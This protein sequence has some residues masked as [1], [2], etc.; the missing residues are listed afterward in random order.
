MPGRLFER[1]VCR[2]GGL[3]ASA[4]DGLRAPRSAALL[5]R[6]AALDDQQGA[7][8]E[9]LSAQ[10]FAAVGG[11]GDPAERRRLLALRRQLHNGRPPD[12]AMVGALPGALAAALEPWTEIASESAA[13]EESLPAIFAGEQAAA[14][15]AFRRQLADRD[16]QHGLLISSRG[17]FAGLPRYLAAGELSAKDRQIERGLL[18]YFTR[19]ALKAT[20]FST[21]CAILPGRIET[22]PAAAGEKLVRLRGEASGKKSHIR[23][24]KG[25]LTVFDELFRRDRLLR[26]LFEVELNPTLET[27]KPGQ[28]RFLAVAGRREIFQRLPDHPVLGLIGALLPTLEPRPTLGRLVAALAAHPELEAD[29]ATI[30]PYLDRLLEIGLL[31]LTFGIPAQDLDWDLEFRR[32]MAGVPAAAA[33]CRFLEKARSLADTYAAA[34]A[35][36]RAAILDRLEELFAPWRTGEWMSHSLRALIYE[37]AGAEAEA[38]VAA[39]DVEEIGRDLAEYVQRTAGL[40]ASR[41]DLATMRYF[42]DRFYAGE[43]EVPLLR[44]YEDFY[45]EVFKRYIEQEQRS[46]RGEPVDEGYDLR[47]PLGLEALERRSA[48][49]T[50]LAELVGER[51]AAASLG[52]ELHL[53]TADLD[54][55]L[56]ETGIS[57]PRG[58][59]G[60]VSMYLDLFRGEAGEPSAVLRGG[61]YF[62]GYGKFFSRFLYL[63]PADFE[64][65][66]LR[67]NRQLC[68][69]DALAEINDDAN[70]NPNLHPP[71][72]EEEIRYP[73]ADPRSAG[74]GLLPSDLVLRRD[75]SADRLMLF[76]PPSGRRILPVDT[77]FLNSDARPPLYR[78]LGAFTPAPSFT[79]ELPKNAGDASPAGK[80]QI[81]R[82]PRVVFNRRLVLA[83]QAFEVPACLF[84][85]K[86]AKETELSYFRRIDGWRRTAGIPR[87]VYAHFER[88]AGSVAPLGDARKPQFVDFASPLLVELFA[89]LPP[90]GDD[91]VLMLEERLPGPGDLAATEAGPV[92][93]ELVVELDFPARP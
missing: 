75:G 80:E 82:R 85:R 7:L 53:S 76:H 91:W 71:L 32:R 62:F 30:V 90:E 68:S 42:F 34:G 28:L 40:A 65:D 67:R 46:T 31:R 70:F 89:A 16:F 38:G 29:E 78:L 12:A 13:A 33:A 19:M 87:E 2:V 48:A 63:F 17:L 41:R 9:R 11:N 86:E 25:L 3:P 36:E 83:R 37:D 92:V 5:D 61:S 47:N 72:T 57:A 84:P 10:L 49:K 81:R 35:V 20:P 23:L 52:G 93:T 79:F 44:F 15:D 54:R 60:S 50:R 22:E 8:R 18:R 88:S 45:R 4:A 39:G 14:R 58:Q 74:G 69:P 73:A 43:D 26:R 56:E 77:G 1:F 27:E 66:L 51:W 55:I 6:L 24:N 64:D 21:F 59:G